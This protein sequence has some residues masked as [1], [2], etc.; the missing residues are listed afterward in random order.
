MEAGK[1]GGREGDKGKDGKYKC[2]SVN[3]E[4]TEN[5]LQ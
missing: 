1:G 3:E 4:D 5:E 2:I